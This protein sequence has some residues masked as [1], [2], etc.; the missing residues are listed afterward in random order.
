MTAHIF[1]SDSGVDINHASLER[2]ASRCLVGGGMSAE[3][4]MEM[5]LH[6]RACQ[7]RVKGCIHKEAC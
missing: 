3:N 7:D 2:Q 1:Q 4:A 5:L 6:I